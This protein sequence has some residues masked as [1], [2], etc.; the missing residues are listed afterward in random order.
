MREVKLT[1]SM[2][3]FIKFG[4]FMQDPFVKFQCALVVEI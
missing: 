1:Q 2:M 3:I 4:F